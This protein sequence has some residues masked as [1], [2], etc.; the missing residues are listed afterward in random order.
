MFYCEYNEATR[1]WRVY[2][3]DGAWY[4]TC[5]HL[6][7]ANA[8]CEAHNAALWDKPE[9]IDQEPE[10][11]A[12][13]DYDESEAWQDGSALSCRGCPDSECTGHCMSCP[14]RSF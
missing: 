8:M 2:D 6:D 14:Y 13:E 7:E 12:E 9:E 10:W 5:K 3:D 4:A 11:H 1:T